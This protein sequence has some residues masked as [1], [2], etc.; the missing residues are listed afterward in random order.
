MVNSLARAGRLINNLNANEI[1]LSSV[2][3][4]SFIILS[5]KIRAASMFWGSFISTKLCK[6]VLVFWRRMIHKYRSEA[7]KV[8][9]DGGGVLRFQ[10]V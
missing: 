3:P 1:L 10:M 5:A 6:G 8:M 2:I 9:A 7:S 4:P